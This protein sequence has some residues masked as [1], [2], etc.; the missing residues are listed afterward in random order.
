M[1]DMS[2]LE[3]VILSVYYGLKRVDADAIK[4]GE[5]MFSAVCYRVPGTGSLT[6]RLDLKPKRD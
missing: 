6:I 2:D 5:E 3:E 4:V 1:S